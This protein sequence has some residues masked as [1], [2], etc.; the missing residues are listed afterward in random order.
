MLKKVWRKCKQIFFKEIQAYKILF[1][2]KN[3]RYIGIKNI[4]LYFIFQRIFRI[5][6]HVLWPVHWSSIV[7]SPE[8]IKLQY[9]RPYPGFMPGCYIQAIN[10]IIIGKNVRIGPGVKIISA[11]HDVN[12]YDVHTKDEPIIIGDNCWLSA[13]CVILPGVKLGNHTIV[14]ANAVVTKSFEKGNCI[15]GG[16]P[17]KIIKEL[18]S[19]KG[20]IK[21]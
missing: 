3:I 8:N 20:Q 19:Y 7:S 10:G 14:A 12:D 16:V 2:P 1:N 21:W 5:N 11:N 18:D 9:W 13:N 4:I 15:I 17:A 6:S